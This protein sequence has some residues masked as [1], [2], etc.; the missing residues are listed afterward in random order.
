MDFSQPKSMMSENYNLLNTM[1]IKF[2]SH[3]TSH[4]WVDAVD[5]CSRVGQL[6][7]LISGIKKLLIVDC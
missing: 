7:T 3:S 6:L 5:C 2:V 4:D 1:S